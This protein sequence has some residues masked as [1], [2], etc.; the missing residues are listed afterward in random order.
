MA[1]EQ[2][3]AE[4]IFRLA[5]ALVEQPGFTGRNKVMETRRR[6]RYGEEPVKLQRVA[7]SIEYRTGL[8]DE[9]IHHYQTAISMATLVLRAIAL[10]DT[11]EDRDRA[12]RAY[13]ACMYLWAAV[14]RRQ[15]GTVASAPGRVA[16]AQAGDG[17]GWYHMRIS[18]T[19]FKRLAGRPLEELKEVVEGGGLDFLPFVVEA[20]DPITV[21]PS[22]DMSMVAQVG[23]VHISELAQHYPELRLNKDT[24]TYHLAGVDSEPLPPGEAEALW[25][26][27]VDIYRVETEDYIY[28][29]LRQPEVPEGSD[30]A[31]QL[32]RLPNIFGRPAFVPV[33]A[34]ITMSADPI[35]AYQPAVVNMYKVAPQKNRMGS[36]Q[37]SAAEMTGSPQ[38]YQRRIGTRGENEED[39][40][41]EPGSSERTVVEIGTGAAEVH[42]KP[43]YELVQVKL[44][45]GID[46]VRAKEDLDKEWYQVGFPTALR[47]PSEV[48][49]T[50]GY[51]RAKIEEVLGN[52]VGYLFAGQGAAWHDLFLL[53]A[54]GLKGLD[55]PLKLRTVAQAAAVPGSPA[56][57][58]GGAE[59]VSSREIVVKPD[60][61]EGVELEVELSSLSRAARIAMQ[62]EGMRLVELKLASNRE[63][64]RDFR[65]VENPDRLMMEMHTEDVR[66]DAAEAVKEAVKIQIRNEMGLPSLQ[67]EPTTQRRERKR[68]PPKGAASPGAGATLVQPAT[69][70]A[71]GEPA[72]PGAEGASQ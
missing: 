41:L 56:W 9:N 65:R 16:D 58:E 5:K 35:K 23:K 63:F 52:E 51:D 18:P 4:K 1:D 72:L 24:K 66:A 50:S 12:Q 11:L 67:P 71:T 13:D 45:A 3:D 55:V 69:P 15:P 27:V 25:K 68:R 8:I 60:D 29:L 38:F 57:Y 43:G 70:K 28:E 37:Q 64:Q 14:H 39:W 33:P 47:L 62:E 34:R 22:R 30:Q 7:T 46:L 49:V 31:L 59:G 6:L 2:P 53:F 40:L 61:F 10:G 19:A 20:C 26:E 32:T 48:R 42:I 44:E 36:L 17:I 21:Y 54:A